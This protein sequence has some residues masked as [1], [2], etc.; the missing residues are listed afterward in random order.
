MIMIVH[1]LSTIYRTQIRFSCRK[2]ENGRISQRGSH[3]ELLAH[4]RRYRWL[5]DIQYGAGQAWYLVIS[6]AT[7][8]K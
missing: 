5:R 7:V 2:H 4:G 6:S 3:E 1:K 8:K